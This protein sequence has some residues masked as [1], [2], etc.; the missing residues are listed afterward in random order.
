MLK[1][2]ESKEGFWSSNQHKEALGL[3]YLKSP[4]G[5]GL[6]L[7]HPAPARGGTAGQAPTSGN[8]RWPAVGLGP[9]RG[10]RERGGELIRRESTKD[11]NLG[12][13]ILGFWVLF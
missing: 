2:E 7:G 1:N 11:S 5:G 9:A 3:L 6:C 12:E 8:R 10:E 13:R 4:R